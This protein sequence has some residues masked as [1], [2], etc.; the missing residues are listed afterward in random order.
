M[1]FIAKHRQLMIALGGV[2]LLAIIYFFFFSSPSSPDLTSSGVP[3]SPTE[4]FFAN[5]QSELT[6]ISFDTALFDD[7]RF[8]ALVD[9][10]TA[11]TDETKGRQDPFAPIPGTATE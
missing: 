5:L 4:L 2:I 1:D 7:P 9:I 11:I 8:N 6:P 3:A 10:R